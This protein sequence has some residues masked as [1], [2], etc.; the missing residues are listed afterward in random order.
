MGFS[1][2]ISR[3]LG[4]ASNTGHFD[5]LVGFQAKFIAGLD[6]GIT[7]GIM[8]TSGT[9]SRVKPFIILPGIPKVISGKIRMTE[10]GTAG[11]HLTPP[12]RGGTPGDVLDM[13]ISPME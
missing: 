4:G 5:H 10:H 3:R 13:S 7:D 1:Q 12:L 9:E 11:L 2:K 8:A 6:N